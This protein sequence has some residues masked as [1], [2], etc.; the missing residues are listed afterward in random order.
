MIELTKERLAELRAHITRPRPMGERA[1]GVTMS[2]AAVLAL[3]D[4]ADERDRLREALD[5]AKLHA[6]AILR[7]DDRPWLRKEGEWMKRVEQWASEIHAIL[8]DA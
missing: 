7:G 2:N 3:L 5:T 1:P 8:E 6:L 4:A